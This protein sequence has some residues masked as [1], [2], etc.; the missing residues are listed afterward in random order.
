MV[1]LCVMA[2]LL[3]ATLSAGGTYACLS[4]C[5]YPFSR[6]TSVASLT[7]VFM[8]CDVCTSPAVPVPISPVVQHQPPSI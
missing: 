2:L 7:V 5:L 1:V 8:P 6:E 4:V 3:T